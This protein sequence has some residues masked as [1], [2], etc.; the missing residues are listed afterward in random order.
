MGRSQPDPPPQST[1]RARGRRKV[2]IPEGGGR[3]R[4]HGSGASGCAS[5]GGRWYV[6]W[7][8]G[9][10]CVEQGGVGVGVVGAWDVVGARPVR[11]EA[12]DRARP[13]PL[14]GDDEDYIQAVLEAARVAG[15][16][17]NRPDEYPLRRQPRG[18]ATSDLMVMLRMM[19]ATKQFIGSLRSNIGQVIYELKLATSHRPSFLD[20]DASG[21]AP[22]SHRAEQRRD[23]KGGWLK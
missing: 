19:A 21:Y 14:L 12:G 8:T 1:E 17:V 22:C 10:V 5:G 11:G 7:G 6:G 4:A 3:H 9:G 18:A 15:L 16:M 20:L 23:G 13:P 2:P